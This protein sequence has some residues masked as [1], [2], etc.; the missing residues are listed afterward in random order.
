M[1]DLP[2]KMVQEPKQKTKSNAQEQASDNRKVDCSVLATMD[3]VAGKTA[4]TEREARAEEEQPANDGDYAAKKKEHAAEFAER[5]HRTPGSK[6]QT[7]VRATGMLNQLEGGEEVADLEGGGVRGVGAVSAVVADAGAEVAADGAGSGFLGVGGPHNVA[8]FEDGAIGFED[9][10]ED[11]AGGHEVG[12]LAEEGAL[13]VDGV[14]A[15][16]FFFGEA[17]G[18]NSDDLETGL[19]DASK[20]FALKVSANGIRFNDCEGAFESQRRFS[21]RV[22][23]CCVRFACAYAGGAS[24]APT[25]T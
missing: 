23:R 5:I 21:D 13:F 10:S 7:K 24:R 2:A 12:E 16:G 15:A 1:W 4:E 3:E 18:F 14:K 25:A 22:L 6:A 8:P 17:H 20:N 19:V 9:E 11:F